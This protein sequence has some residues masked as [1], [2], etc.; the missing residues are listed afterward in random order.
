VGYASA[1]SVV[2]FLIVLLI[3][4]LQRVFLREE[5]QVE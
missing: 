5:R 4:M 1:I 3:S 2:F